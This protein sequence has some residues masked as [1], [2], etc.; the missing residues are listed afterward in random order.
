MPD[1]H[2]TGE[3]PNGIVVKTRNIFFPKLVGSDI[4]CGITLYDLGFHT[5]IV[6]KSFEQIQAA[7]F[8]KKKRHV[9][10]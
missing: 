3:F 1:V 4:G 8:T 5:S 7:C 2:E 9:I 6:L 10:F